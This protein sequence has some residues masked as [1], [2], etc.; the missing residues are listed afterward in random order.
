MIDFLNGYISPNTMKELKNKYPSQLFNLNC[1]QK[2]CIKVIEYLKE[3]GIKNIEEI[4]I[5]RIELFYETKKD[6]EKLFLKHDIP[7]L[8]QKIN[9]DYMEI[10]ILFD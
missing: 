10:D 9:D 3:L 7:N 5:N 4:F 1:N 8:V 2:E 6:L